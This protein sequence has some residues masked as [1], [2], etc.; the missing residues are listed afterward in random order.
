V[1][2]T[3]LIGFIMGWLIDRVNWFEDRF[4]LQGVSH[5]ALHAGKRF[6]QLANQFE[7][8][9]LRPRYLVLFV[10]ITLLVAF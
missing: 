7:F 9:V 8:I 5:D 4:V 6:G 2:K 3:G 10:F 1:Y